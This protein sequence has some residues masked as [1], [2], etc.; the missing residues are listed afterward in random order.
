MQDHQINST[1]AFTSDD[2]YSS[3]PNKSS[4]HKQHRGQEEETDSQVSFGKRSQRSFKFQS[5]KPIQCSM[6]TDE[7]S[8]QADDTIR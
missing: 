1:T 3:S 5:M 2:Y 6:L 8:D 7:A 4:G